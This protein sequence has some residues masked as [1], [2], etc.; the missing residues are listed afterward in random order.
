M[1]YGRSQGARPLGSN[2]GAK[3]D[4]NK[5]IKLMLDAVETA[6]ALSISQ[7][8]LATLTKDNAAPHLRVR[9]RVLYAVRELEAWID[10]GGPTEPGSAGLVRDFLRNGGAA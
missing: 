5:S 2:P 6:E 8:T 1:R 7:R 4:E 10:C 9:R 3:I